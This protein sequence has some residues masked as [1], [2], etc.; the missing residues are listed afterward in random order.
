MAESSKR[1]GAARGGKGASRGSGGKNRRGLEG[2]GPTPKAEERPQH[3][4]Y[5]GG[6]FGTSGRSGAK[7]GAPRAGQRTKRSEGKST[8]EMIAGR[9][10]VL[11]A[12]QEKVPA[13]ALYLGDGMESDGRISDIL[14]LAAD[15]RL[16]LMEVTRRELDRLT[17]R[18]VHQG[19]ALKVP[20]YAY[21]SLDDLMSR[22]SDAFESPLLVALDGVTDP[23]NLGAILRSAGAFGAHGLIVPQRR[24][25]GMTATA[26]KAAA[27]AAAR[28]PV[29]QV[30]NLTQALK[31]LKSRGV[32]AAGLAADGDATVRGT[33]L[34]TGPLVLVVGSEGKG[35]SRL[36][37]DTCDEIVSVPIGGRTESLNASVATA[38]AL[39]EVAQ[40]RA[41][42]GHA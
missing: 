14:R 31:D 8:E 9:N 37:R 40:A 34:S 23:H 4:K 10:S 17:D 3:K 38:I 21:A 29:A 19:V 7:T 1:A 22:A 30:V 5:S 11:E 15:R 26:W 33:G 6:S 24:S 32:F 42:Q 2:R 41:E 39:Y 27:G 20:P 13:T 28:V 25:A 16:P 36:V 35:L 18:T 12:L